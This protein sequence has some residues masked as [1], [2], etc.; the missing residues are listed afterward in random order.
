MIMKKLTTSIL[1]LVF[2]GWLHA[3]P[4]MVDSNGITL[5]YE[6]FGDN[7]GQTIILIQGTGAPMTNWPVALCER[8]ANAG[9]RVI[10]FDNRDIG[11]STKLDS[12]GLPNWEAITPFIKTCRPAPLPYTLLDMANDVIGMMN[13]LDIKRAH[14][15]GA[16]M[17]GAIA[18]LIAI[19][20]PSRVITLASISASSGD[21]DL[22]APD[23]AGLQAINTPPPASNNKDTL[24][25]YLVNTYRALGNRDDVNLLKERA[26]LHINRS[27]HPEGT[28]RQVAAT[29]VG[30][31][32]DRRTELTKKVNVPA[33]IIHGDVD[34]LVSAEAA[35]ELAASIKNSELYIINGMG[36]DLSEM[37]INPIVDLILKNVARSD[38]QQVLK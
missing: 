8:L 14:I 33:I 15:V 27:W 4:A 37:F 6:S 5:A 9:Y 29:A 18:Q 24:A 32:C 1:L 30:D 36:H 12:L 28:A 13:T 7:S 34:P 20:F 21:P 19:N 35:N 11:L 17:G 25:N 10:R 3:Q 23:P 26:L 2:V 16:S 22:P 31:N 38:S